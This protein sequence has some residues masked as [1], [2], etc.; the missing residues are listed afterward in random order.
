MRNP[1]KLLAALLLIQCI[2]AATPI[3]S[4]GKCPA[5][6]RNL[7]G[8]HEWNILRLPGTDNAVIR[9]KG[10]IVNTGQQKAEGVL[11]NCTGYDETDAPIFSLSPGHEGQKLDG[12]QSPPINAG[13]TLGFKG[14]YEGGLSWD[15]RQVE[16]MVSAGACRKLPYR[17]EFPADERPESTTSITQST[18]TAAPT[19]STGEKPAEKKPGAAASNWMPAAIIIGVSF[20]ALISIIDKKRGDE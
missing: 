19:A 13:E 18:S 16:C 4:P 8:S 6:E 3:Q 17:L 12:I 10:E 20:F 11:V 9:V 2:W 7:R 14:A 1:A 15:T 5:A